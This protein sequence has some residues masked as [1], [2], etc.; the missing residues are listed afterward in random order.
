MSF[1]LED[2]WFSYGKRVVLKGITFEVDKGLT[3][4]IGPNGAGKSTLLKCI[5]GFLKPFRGRISLDGED[6]MALPR[7]KVSKLVG[8]VPQRSYPS[9]LTVFDA[10]LMG[11]MPY[12]GWSVRDEDLKVVEE[13][14]E[15]FNLK[16]LAYRRVDSLSGGEFQKVALA[17]AVAQRPKVL[18]LD[19]PT[20]NLDI[21]SQKDVMDV[22]T[23]L[24]GISVLL[25]THDISLA[26]RYAKSVVV[27]KDGE[28]M[29]MGPK[30][31]L[32]GSLLTKAYGVSVDIE[33]V[34]GRL[35][36]LS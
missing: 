20:S 12:M 26:L 3:T 5:I 2:V 32:N 29:W 30:E 28:V 34:R 18:L 10:V 33:R 4:I 22:V 1:K 24:S 23:G 15:L 11:R 31:D 25:V 8:Y 19:E 16:D 27:M 21:K 6:L 17:R 14:L 36:V 9:S 35:F 13:V 7:A